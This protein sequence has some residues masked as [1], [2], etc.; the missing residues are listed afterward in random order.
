[1]YLLRHGNFIDLKRLLSPS[2]PDDESAKA[3]SGV[4]VCA[5]AIA[6]YN[7]V[8]VVR[9]RNLANF[10]T[11]KSL[12]LEI[13]GGRPLRPQRLLAFDLAGVI[14]V[15]MLPL[16]LVFLFCSA[17]YNRIALL[18]SGTAEQDRTSGDD[19]RPA[20]PSEYRRDLRVSYCSADNLGPDK[21][22]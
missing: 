4:L 5:I 20:A 18:S 15:Y 3:F 19:D 16:L 12:S 6:H 21:S 22:A 7:Q 11:G 10:L 1:M 13:R 9:L 2:Q 14:A 8:D 17:L